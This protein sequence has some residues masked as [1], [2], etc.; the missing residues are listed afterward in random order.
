MLK[1]VKFIVYQLY[2]NKPFYKNANTCVLK[3]GVPGR[4]TLSGN[5]T[6]KT[7]WGRGCS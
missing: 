3:V 4:L 2:F 6:E 7:P 5:S 1:Y